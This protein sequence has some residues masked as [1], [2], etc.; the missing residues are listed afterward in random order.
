MSPGLAALEGNWIA[1]LAD[2]AEKEKAARSLRSVRSHS[3][4][5]ENG[6]NP[7]NWGWVGLVLIFALSRGLSSCS[8]SRNTLPP[9]MFR[10]WQP[11]KQ[12]AVAPKFPFQEPKPEGDVDQLKEIRRIIEEQRRRQNSPKEPVRNP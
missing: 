4:R 11:P 12:P 1:G 10:N 6:S 8:T 9:E 2:R 3:S 5:R 7:W